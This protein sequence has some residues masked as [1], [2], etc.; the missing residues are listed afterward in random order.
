MT[1]EQAFPTAP[2]SGWRTRDIVV[3]ATIG[4]AF[5]VVFWFWNIF[6]WRPAEPLFALLPPARNVLYGLWLIPAVLAPLVIRRP[7]AAVF[8]EMVA[9][10][11]SALLGTEWGVDVLLSGFVQGAA[12]ELVFALTLYRLWTPPVLGAA[13]LASA[14]AAWVHDWAVWYQGLGFDVMGLVLGFMAVSALALTAGGSLLL[15]NALRR[16]GVLEGFPA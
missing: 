3:A 8:A 7:G 11:V 5:G 15:A 12:A 6:V 1:A 2:A 9:A 4:V 14:L 10:V 13:A 16:A